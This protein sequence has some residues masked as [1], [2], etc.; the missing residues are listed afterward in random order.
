MN[1]IIIC[2]AVRYK[3][4]IW[5]GHRHP[6]ALS[7]MKDTLSYEMNRKEMQENSVGEDQGF[8][9]SLNRYVNREEAW[10]IALKAKQIKDIELHVATNSHPLLFSEDIY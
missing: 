9:T 7:A 2:A 6:Q 8:V 5:M 1:E 4:K 3:D 10:E